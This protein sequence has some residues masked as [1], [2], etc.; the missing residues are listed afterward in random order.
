MSKIIAID[1]GGTNLRVTL[2]KIIKLNKGKIKQKVY[3]LNIINKNSMLPGDPFGLPDEY[4]H[5]IF[6]AKD[7]LTDIQ[8]PSMA[9]SGNAGLP[10]YSIFSAIRFKEAKK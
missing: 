9:L 10:I 5:K 4:L 8:A 1:L 6:K 3:K 7:I 2:L